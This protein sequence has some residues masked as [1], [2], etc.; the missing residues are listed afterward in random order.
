MIGGWGGKGVAKE[1]QRTSKMTCEKTFKRNPKKNFK[2]IHKR[3]TNSLS[4]EKVS[5][6]VNHYL[7]NDLM[8][9]PDECSSGPQTSSRTFKR[10]S[11]K[12][13]KEFKKEKIH[14]RWNTVVF[15][16]KTFRLIYIT[17]EKGLL[18]IFPTMFCRDPGRPAGGGGGAG[19]QTCPPA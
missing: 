13:Q 19:T 2:R 3:W 17:I 14:K 8:D 5:F 1:C 11:K 7:K 16:M 9:I 4:N 15:P 10:T 6:H 12:I 18:W